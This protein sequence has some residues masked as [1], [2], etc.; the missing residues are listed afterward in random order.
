MGSFAQAR[1]FSGGGDGQS[2]AMMPGTPSLV[3]L[4]LYEA[5][6]KWIY[7]TGAFGLTAGGLA[8]SEIARRVIEA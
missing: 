2:A 8:C 7:G 4:C 1:R 5:P 3:G 6:F